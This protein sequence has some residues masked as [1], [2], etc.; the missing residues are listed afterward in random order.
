MPSSDDD[1]SGFS[2]V[3]VY[4]D[5]VTTGCTAGEKYPGCKRCHFAVSSVRANRAALGVTEIVPVCRS[6]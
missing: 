4:G 5:A 1:S 2:R 3:L 6:K